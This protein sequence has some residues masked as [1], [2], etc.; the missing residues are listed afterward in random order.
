[1]PIALEMTRYRLEIVIPAIL[2]QVVSRNQHPVT[3][4]LGPA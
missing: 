3:I 1:M 4:G 2:N